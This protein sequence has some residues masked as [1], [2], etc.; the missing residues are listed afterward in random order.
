MSDEGLLSSMEP[1]ALEEPSRAAP[2]GTVTPSSAAG[3]TPSGPAQVAF[4]GG[5]EALHAR[6]ADALRTIY[7]PEI[8]VNIYEL[9]LVYRVEIDASN[10]AT[11]HMTLTS[12]AC[13]VAGSLPGEV[14]AKVGAVSGVSGAQVELVWMP[15]W[16][17]A[18]M[19][20][21]A[22]LLLNLPY[23]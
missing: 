12:P 22:K 21:E 10:M 23:Y 4:S 13:P 6:I 2:A 15:P 1:R 5:D 19:S 9:G 16:T 18:M 7:D 14:Q 8:P 17:P 20:E 3:N 11:V